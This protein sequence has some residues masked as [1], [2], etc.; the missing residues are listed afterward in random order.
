M[1][2]SL[3]KIEKIYVIA[4]NHS[5]EKYNDIKK[6]LNEL[7]LI[8]DV[9][10]EII[11]GHNAFTEKLPKDAKAYDKWKLDSSDNVYWQNDV[12]TGEIGCAL[13]HVN[14]WN[15]I[16]EDGVSRALVLEEDFIAHKP[17]KT[18][19]EPMAAWDYMYLGRY[20]FDRSE[21]VK[22]DDQW[23]RPGT[24]YNTHAYVLTNTGAKKL[25]DYNLQSNIFASDEFITATYMKHRRED[26]EALYPV[27]KIKAISTNED[28]IR[29]TSNAETSLVSAHGYSENEKPKE[30]TND[31]EILDYSNWDAWV[32][33]YVAPVML[34]RDYELMTDDLG[35]NIIEFPLFTDT[36]CEE[37]IQLAESKGEWTMGRHEFYPTNDMLMETLG[38]KDI[39]T[40]VIREYVAPL[41][42]WY[43]TLEGQGWDVVEDETF[44]IR[45]KPDLQG[46]LSV[47]HDHSSY[48][49]GVKLNDEFEGGGTFF[50]KYGV[51][52]I[53]KRNGNAFLHPGMITH[54]HG[55]RPVYSGT[56]Y[57]AVSFIR[58][59]S[60]LK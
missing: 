3:L 43:F 14:V 24:S 13:S 56:R 45:Y 10:F 30:K 5:A 57:I 59:N 9:S 17:I 33:K 23:V 44:I 42:T 46:Q 15:K 16:V 31:M 32:S 49:I 29:Q 11:H 12:T 36:F 7:E 27:K 34:Q 6:R 35:P 50:P 20:V 41:A 47:H 8:K 2:R 48:T 19:Y 1:I 39:Y 22:L 38:M 58:N 21:D 51:N 40:R 60:I 4:I 18:L 26:I 28:Y 54:R 37:L 53:P 55:G 52:A 25:I